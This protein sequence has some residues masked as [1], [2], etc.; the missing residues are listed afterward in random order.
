MVHL[1]SFEEATAQACF[2]LLPAL[3]LVGLS[4]PNM[5]NPIMDSPVIINIAAVFK[6]FYVC[7][8]P[9]GE[10]SQ[11]GAESLVGLSPEPTSG[12]LRAGE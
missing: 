8:L 12:R 2:P 7:L 5:A 10:V 1:S 11:R 4:F 9:G 6:P 3:C